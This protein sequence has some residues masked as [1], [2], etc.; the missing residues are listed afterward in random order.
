V[1]EIPVL[2]RNTQGVKLINVA[3]EERLAGVER[4]VALDGGEEDAASDTDTE[5]NQ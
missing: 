3:G 5:E 4:I 2:S 1:A